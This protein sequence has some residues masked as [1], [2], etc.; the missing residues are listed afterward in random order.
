MTLVGTQSITI[1]MKFILLWSYIIL[2]NHYRC[3]LSEGTT[4]TIY[5]PYIWIILHRNHSYS[6]AV[7]SISYDPAE[8]KMIFF[9]YGIGPIGLVSQ[10]KIWISFAEKQ[11]LMSAS[12]ETFY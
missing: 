7:P 11:Q 3:Q 10:I 6:S 4:T 5:L 1:S 12:W 9:I 2:E 8:H